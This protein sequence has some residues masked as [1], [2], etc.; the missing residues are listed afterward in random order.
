MNAEDILAYLHLLSALVYA[1][2]L[3][4]VML[5]LWRAWRS[6]DVQ[7][8]VIAFDEASLYEGFLLLP[9]MI[10]VGGT[11]IFLW[12]EIGY[13]LVTTGW[14]LALGVLYLIVLLICLPMIG[15][16]LH[17]TRLLTLQA[18]KTGRMTAELERALADKVPLVFGAIALLILPAMVYLSVFKPL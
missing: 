2:G 7:Y 5:T 12:T 4:V 18:A 14:F 10:A 8:R 3:A 9:A 11:G 16:G 13:S 15:L 1:A 6:P 17:R